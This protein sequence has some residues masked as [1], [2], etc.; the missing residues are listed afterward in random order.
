MPNPSSNHRTGGK[1]VFWLSLLLLGLV[2]F[3]PGRNVTATT[4]TPGPHTTMQDA[5]TVP[6]DPVLKKATGPDRGKYQ[7]LIDSAA[8]ANALQA[9]GLIDLHI[10]FASGSAR[11]TPNARKL[12]GE[13]AQALHTPE[14]RPRRILITG[15][16]DWVGPTAANLKLSQQRARAVKSALVKLGI[17]ADRLTTRGLGESQPIADNHTAAGR[18]RNR[19]VTLSLLPE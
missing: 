4:A 7:V 11:L 5:F 6:A 13:I 19:R 9:Q 8:I 2:L 18:A 3:L 14:L 15:H 1:T 17:A 12:V 10:E 16:T